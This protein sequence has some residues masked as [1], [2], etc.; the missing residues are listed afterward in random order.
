MDQE[1]PEAVKEQSIRI[2]RILDANYE[3]ANFEQEVN[4]LIHLTKFQRVIL[5]IFLKQYEDIF[6]DDLGCWTG[7][8][9]YIPL[10]DK[11]NTHHERSLP[12]PV[13]HLEPKKI[14]EQTS[15]YRRTDKN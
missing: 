10:Q 8:L 6:D 5:L 9:V 3:K 13:T 1:D 12:I 2:S 15:R 11:V 4:K 7:L 14:F